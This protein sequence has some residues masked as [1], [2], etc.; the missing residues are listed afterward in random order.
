MVS[1]KLNPWMGQVQNTVQ[2]FLERRVRQH[3]GVDIGASSCIT[4]NIMV[5]KSVDS[6]KAQ[7]VA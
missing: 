4:R 5:Q 7:E 6:I 1:L 3:S 2:H